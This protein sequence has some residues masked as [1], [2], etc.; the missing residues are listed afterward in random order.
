MNPISSTTQANSR[1]SQVRQRRMQ[2]TQ[3]RI[4]QI[5]KRAQT[6]TKSQPVVMRGSTA[7]AV[8]TARPMHQNARGNVRRQYYYSL[9]A[10]GVEV[11]LPSIP[12]VNFG[13]RAASALLVVVMMICIFMMLG[14]ST[15]E[16]SGLT[17]VGLQRLS[18]TDVET[19]LKL[20]GTAALDI[21]P[22]EVKAQI[23]ALFPELTDVDVRVGLPAKVEISVR[24]RQPIVAWQMPEQTVWVDAEGF[25]IPARGEVSGLV[26][27]QADGLPELVAQTAAETG[28]AADGETTASDLLAAMTTTKT[29]VAGSRIDINLLSAALK[30]STQVP[31]GASLAYTVNDGLGWADARGWK[32]YIGN[33]LSNLETKLAEYEAIVA[34]LTE[35]G[36]TPVMISVEHLNAP[37]FRTE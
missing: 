20:N 5:N 22:E 31:E 12:M 8:K 19:A 15:F 18:A 7:S 23:S 26:T 1:A 17:M 33:D 21:H 36:I 4:D 29:T 24:E 35:R 2:Q 30:L 34:Q 11:R 16:V 14:S 32:V 9:D 13:W 6:V 37:F 27:L 3:T 10:S 28:S 25:I